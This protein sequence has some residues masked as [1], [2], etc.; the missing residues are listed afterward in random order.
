MGHTPKEV[1]A[2][3]EGPDRNCSRSGAARRTAG[4]EAGGRYLK[5]RISPGLAVVTSEFRLL[6]Y[7]GAHA[8]L[9][10]TD[11]IFCTKLG[12]CLKAALSLYPPHAG[13]R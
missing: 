13:I 9:R 6:L 12:R 7:L 5:E 1:I 8:V 10:D 3:F 4:G 11:V 2:V